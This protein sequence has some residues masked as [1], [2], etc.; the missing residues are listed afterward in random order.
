MSDGIDTDALWRL[1]DAHL[2]RYGTAFIR[3]LVTRAE[4][5]T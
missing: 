5:A 1:A 2:T 3:T 4:G